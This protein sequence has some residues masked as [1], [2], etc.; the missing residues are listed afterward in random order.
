MVKADVNAEQRLQD[1]GISL[2][3][4]PAPLGAYVEAVRTGNLLFLTGM[5][6]VVDG[7]AKYVGR[8][9]ADLDL[10]AGRDAAYIAFLNG[11]AVIREHLGSLDKVS[12]IVRLC[13]HI[14]ADADFR[15]HPKLADGASELL[16]DIFGKERTSTRMVL[17]IAS[18]PLGAPVAV[19]LIV[20]TAG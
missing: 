16:E 7:K 5:L 1:L 10:E 18:L 14:V 15:D 13:V 19:E 2:P 17:G 8:I 9:G 6:P 11:L 3:P 20:E 12:R 4:S